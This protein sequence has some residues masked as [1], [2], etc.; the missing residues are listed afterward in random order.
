MQ[1]AFEANA[2][3]EANSA[4]YKR[5]IAIPCAEHEPLCNFFQVTADM[6]V[7]HIFAFTTTMAKA[8]ATEFLIVD[9]FLVRPYV[10]MAKY[11]ATVL[12]AAVFVISL[13]F[14]GFRGRREASAPVP[15][16]I[17]NLS[18]YAIP[19]L[20]VIVLASG[21]G[22]FTVQF[23]SEG[24]SRKISISDNS[25]VIEF[26]GRK[27]WINLNQ[28]DNFSFGFFPFGHTLFLNRFHRLGRLTVSN[29]GTRRTFYF[30]LKNTYQAEEIK[31]F[32][33]KR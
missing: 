1:F 12:L 16:V 3:S 17:T 31:T 21:V 20:I 23:I 6:S 14:L 30:P 29:R 32:H 18:E 2:L 4:L 9:V 24:T 33:L 25:V 27:E 7:S 26:Q 19:V 22:A 15:T 28:V 8:S 11:V 13:T 10:R 5:L